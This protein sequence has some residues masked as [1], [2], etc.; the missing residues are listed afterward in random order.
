MTAKLSDVPKAVAARISAVPTVIGRV[1][2]ATHR[3]P[4]AYAWEPLGGPI[5]GPRHPP[6][7]EPHLIGSWPLRWE[8]DCWGRDLDEATLLVA[9]L[10]TAAHGALGGRRFTVPQVEA[11]PKDRVSLGFCWVVTLELEL[12]LP[13]TDN[14]A[15]PV[16]D[17]ATTADI[18]EIE[19]VT[20][21]TSASGDNTLEGTEE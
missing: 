18:D 4:P 10:L 21:A 5:R 11:A 1:E 15:L 9:A 3:A 14:T 17:E 20:P 6:T 8:I 16:V 19:Q 7:Q 13:S 2:R 12:D